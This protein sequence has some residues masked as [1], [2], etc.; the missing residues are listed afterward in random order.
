MAAESAIYASVR[1]FVVEIHTFDGTKFWAHTY[2]MTEP[3]LGAQLGL[4]M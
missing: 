1:W 3:K 4:R 2:R